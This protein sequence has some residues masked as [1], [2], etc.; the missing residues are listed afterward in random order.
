VPSTTFPAALP[1]LRKPDFQVNGYRLPDWCEAHDTEHQC[2]LC[3]DATWVAMDADPQDGRVVRRGMNGRKGLRVLVQ[4]QCVAARP[5]APFDPRRFGVPERLAEATLDSWGP[6][7]TRER[8]SA[9]NYLVGWP[10]KLPWLVLLG[11]AGRGKTG[12]AVA[13]VRAAYERYGVGGRITTVERAL[14]RFKATFDDDSRTETTEQVAQSY[15]A[16]P[17]LVLDDLGA[18]K[19]TAWADET[20]FAV[21]NGRY[22]AMLPTIVTANEENDGFKALHPRLISRLVDVSTSTVVRF[23]GPDRRRQGGSA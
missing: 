18:T 7:N 9:A 21:L 11:Q 3:D 19:A 4:C 12:L 6:S 15:M 1:T 13:I 20:I 22:E 17:L 16:V 2:C 23:T 5:L 8:I 10:P 14:A